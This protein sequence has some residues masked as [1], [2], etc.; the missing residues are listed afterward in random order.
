MTK[1]ELIKLLEPYPNGTHILLEVHYEEYARTE[2][3]TSMV[4]DCNFKVQPRRKDKSVIV[5]YGEESR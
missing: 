1:G 4:A 3:D 5:I 2:D